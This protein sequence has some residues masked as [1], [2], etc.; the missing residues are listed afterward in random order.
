M[1]RAAAIGLVLG[2]E[3]HG[4]SA[5]LQAL[6]RTNVRLPMTGRADSLNVS[7]AAGIMMYELVRRRLTEL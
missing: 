1:P 5:G 4:L 3:R 2:E 7:I 6:C